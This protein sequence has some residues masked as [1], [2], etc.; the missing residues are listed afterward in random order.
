MPRANLVFVYNADQGFFNALTDTAH[1]I[2]SPHTYQCSLCRY[3]YGLTGML[4]PWK[5]FLESLPDRPV[6]FHRPDFRKEYPDFAVDLPVIFREQ[7][8][9]RE[10]VLSAEEIAQTGGIDGLIAA[11]A[12]KLGVATKPSP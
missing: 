2:F 10:I 9:R 12:N 1:K 4:F 7:A 5:H 3:T 6:F 11:V 8:G